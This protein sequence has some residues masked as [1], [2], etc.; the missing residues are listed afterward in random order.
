MTVFAHFISINKRLKTIFF[1]KFTL[2]WKPFSTCCCTVTTNEF[3]DHYF[4]FPGGSDGKA[5]D[6]NAENAG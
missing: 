2:F 5:S 6:Y 4:Y 3:F 1:F